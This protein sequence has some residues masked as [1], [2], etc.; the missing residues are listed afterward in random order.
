M[1]VQD[2]MIREVQYCGPDTNLAAAAKMMWDSDC[3]VLPILNVQGQV[4]GVITD[5]DICMAAST[6]DR[7]PS[8]IT[9]WEASSGK[10][11]TCH[12]D[13]DIRTALDLMERGKVRRL[14]V[15]DEDGILQGMLSMNDLV[16][17]AGEHRGRSSPELSVENVMKA[18]KAVCAHRALV[19]I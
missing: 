3:G 1:K 15:V 12:L 5:R 19:G 2:I 8:A 4:L 16:L 9:V 6:K 18:L 11:I 14:P 13:D 17:A 7:T 10:A